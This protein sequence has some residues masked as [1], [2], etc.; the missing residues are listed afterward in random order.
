MAKGNSYDIKIAIGD[1]IGKKYF[2]N[3]SSL[4][5]FL[6]PIFLIIT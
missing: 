3:L 2:K 4:T 1:K 5:F 6:S